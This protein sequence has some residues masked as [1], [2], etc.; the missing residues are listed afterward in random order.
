MVFGI[1]YKDYIVC[2]GF[3]KAGSKEYRESQMQERGKKALSGWPTSENQNE[4]FCIMH[5]AADNFGKLKRVGMELTKKKKTQKFIAKTTT[6]TCQASVR[7]S[8][9]A[10]CLKH[11]CSD[12]DKR[13]SRAEEL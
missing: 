4:V 10:R 1:T 3:V 7:V 5:S 9:D 12:D 13:T 8:S 11:E 2:K 6:A